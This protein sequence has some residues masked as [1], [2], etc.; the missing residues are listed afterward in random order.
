MPASS[1]NGS[2]PS[3]CAMKHVSCSPAVSTLTLR[4]SC[5]S[6]SRTRYGRR[7]A[8]RRFPTPNRTS[9]SLPLCPDRRSPTSGVL[10]ERAA[11]IAL[12]LDHPIYDCLY[13]ACAE[14]TD[15]AVITADRRF[16]DKAVGRPLGIPVHHIAAPDVAG[17]I[18]TAGDR[19]GDRRRHGQSADCRIRILCGNGAIGS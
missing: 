17:R 14:A 7:R 6:S 11:R 18:E 2:C 15:S 12:E 16:A 13:L 3:R 10:V 8:R 19:A 9:K 4:I 5:S 1:S